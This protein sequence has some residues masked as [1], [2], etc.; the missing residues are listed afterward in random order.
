MIEQTKKLRLDELQVD[1]FVTALD[2]EKILQTLRGGYVEE[3]FYYECEE[4]FDEING[5]KKKKKAERPTG[6]DGSVCMSAN[7]GTCRH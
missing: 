7:I 6:H 5:R 3:S 4:S 2:H 1:S